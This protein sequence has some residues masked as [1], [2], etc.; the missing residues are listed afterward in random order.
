[1]STREKPRCVLVLG[2][3]ALQIGQAGEFDYSGSQALKALREEGVR[4]VLLNPNIAT[5]Q[6]SQELADEVYFLPVEPDFVA[7]IIERENVDAIL[8]AFG[9]QTA[10]NCG[11]ALDQA[12]TLERAGVRVLGTPPDAI[13]ATEDRALFN[14]KLAEIDVKVARSKHASTPAEVLSAALKIGLPVIL[15]AGFSLGGK[16][17]AIARTEDELARLSPRALSGGNGVLVEECLSGWKEIEYEIVRDGSDN[18]VTVCNMENVDPM[19]IHTGESIVVA[20]TQTL[21]DSD[22]Q[23]LR[24]IALKTARHLGIVGECNIQYA[25]H[26]DTGDYRV[27]EVNARLSRSS[28]LASKATGYPLAYVAAK[29]ALGYD[30]WEIPNGVTKVTTS[31]FE[32]ALDYIVC[33]LPRWDFAKFAGS[34]DRIGPEMKSVGE[35]M[36][37]GRTFCEA[38]QKGLRMLEIGARGLDPDAFAFPDVIRELEEPSSRRMFAVVKA[39]AGGM[40]VDEVHDRTGIDPFF[41][42]EIGDACALRARI[43]KEATLPGPA[44]MRAAKRAGFSDLQIGALVGVAESAA[45]ATRPAQGIHPVLAAID[46]LAAEYPAQ[47]CYLYFT[48]GGTEIE[49]PRARGEGAVLI[50]GSG[51]YRIGS[52]VEFDWSCVGALRACREVGRRTVLLNNNPET[53]STDYDVCDLL[54]FDELSLETVVETVRALGPAG[55]LVSVGGQTANNLVRGLV[56]EGIPI[57]GTPAAA[58]DAAEDR[59]KFSALCD[60]LSIQQPRW[61]AHASADD[62]DEAVA[63]V[64]GYPVIVRP[65][66]VLSGAAMRVAHGP[67]ELREYLERAALVSPEHPVVISKFEEDAREIEVEA[68]ARGGVIEHWAIT[69]HVDNAGVHSGDATLVLPPQHL[70]TETVRRAR[71]IVQALGRALEVTGPFNVQMLARENEVK[72]IECNLRASRSLPFVSKALGIDFVREATLAVLGAPSSTLRRDPLDLDFVAVKVPQFSYRRIDGADP[73]LR[74]EMTSTG[75]AG[76]FGRTLEEALMKAMLSVGFRYPERGVLLSLGPVRAKYRFAREARL[77]LERG[78]PLYATGGTAD[79]LAGEGISCVRVSKDEGTRDGPSALALLREKK[80][81]FVINVAREYDAHGIPDGAL[82]RRLAVDLEVPLITDLMLA[83]AVVHAIVA[84][85][86]DHLEVLPWRSYR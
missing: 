19:G 59:G 79:V 9:G 8:L 21:D 67:T 34:T 81:D 49:I 55:V 45:R 46:T 51:C 37:I 68:V 50:L 63:S 18:A 5:V 72:V 30:L 75:E 65:S 77:L 78:L 6:T 1:M 33:K 52:S 39:L 40:S 53:V 85:P 27:I 74:V 82:I 3:G 26:P 76:C 28:A 11:L 66:Y 57:L 36:A 83:R 15:R 61:L 58:I 56:T 32:P 13:R 71:R 12:G 23:L 7:Q 17:A 38:L 84:C 16:G 44:L 29:I 73:T 86:K 47:T 80:V 48:Y 31:F 22:H 25:L 2:S 42:G 35:V 20:P 69:E 10:L 14:A 62:I 64:G 60:R 70:Y 4:T 54:V 41:L 24:N 43:A